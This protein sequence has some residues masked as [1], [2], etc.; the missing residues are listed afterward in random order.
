M[1]LE[2]GYRL[3]RYDIRALIGSGGM[4]EVY[5]AHDTKLERKVA[6]KLL[7]SQY[8]TNDDRLQ[9]FAREAR[10]VSGLNHPN[11]VTVYDVDADGGTHFIATEFI[12]GETLR[13]Q[14]RRGPIPV[15]EALRIATR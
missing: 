5:L 13:S 11:I 12:D 3:D 15:S 14:L 4:G 1:P 9:R 10:A 2:S 8:T 6:L 7:L